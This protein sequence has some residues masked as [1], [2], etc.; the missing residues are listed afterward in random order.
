MAN[1]IVEF[2]SNKTQRQLMK[3]NALVRAS[4]YQAQPIMHQFMGDL[5]L[6][7]PEHYAIKTNVTAI[8][9]TSTNSFIPAEIE[10]AYC[11]NESIPLKTNSLTEKTVA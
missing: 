4:Q 2:F 5:G 8:P 6:D 9:C 11:E 10:Y 1:K 3:N 7:I